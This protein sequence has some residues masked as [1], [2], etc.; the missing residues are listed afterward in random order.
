MLAAAVAL[1]CAVLAFSIGPAIVLLTPVGVVAGLALRAAWP[2]GP[3]RAVALFMAGVAVVAGAY[4][5]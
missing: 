5:W 4:V 1:A 3:T 2:V